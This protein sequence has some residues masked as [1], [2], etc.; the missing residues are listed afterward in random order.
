M[1]KGITKDEI[2]KEA[3]VLIKENGLSSFSLHSLASNLQVKTASLYSHVSGLDEVIECAS[4]EILL[5]YQKTLEKAV[6]GKSRKDALMSLAAAERRFA[7]KNPHFYSL[8]MNL[9]LSANKELQKVAS[10][11]T[12]PVMKV[13]DGFNLSQIQ[14][15]NAERAFRSVVYGF[16]SQEKHG[17]FS[18]F[19]G[20]KEKSFVFAV[21]AVC[22]GIEKEE[23][24]HS[25]LVS[26]SL[27]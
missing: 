3:K 25:E 1:T 4:K 21:N 27:S 15:T 10:C 8:I 14:K 23:S 20:S 17:Y 5:E 11:I 6:E 13:L 22:D 18:H 12:V 19:K 26:E 2:I 9:E 16:I 24:R 7:K